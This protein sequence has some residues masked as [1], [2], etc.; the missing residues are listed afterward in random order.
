MTCPAP[1][2]ADAPRRHLPTPEGTLREGVH[3]S[4]HA[5]ATETRR[6]RLHPCRECCTHTSTVS[7]EPVTPKSP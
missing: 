3:A 7:Q 2:E 6:I 5:P 4:Q 1:G